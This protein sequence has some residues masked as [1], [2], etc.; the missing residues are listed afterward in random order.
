[1]YQVYAHLKEIEESSLFV[2]VLHDK[3]QDRIVL[4]QCFYFDDTCYL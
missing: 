3:V 2:Y 4:N 1:M